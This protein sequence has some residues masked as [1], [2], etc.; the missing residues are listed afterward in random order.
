MDNWF[1]RSRDLIIHYIWIEQMKLKVRIKEDIRSESKQKVY[2]TEVNALNY[3]E[4]ALIFTD[5]KNFGLPIE[6]A[7]KEFNL[8]KSDWNIALGI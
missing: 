3:K 4:L 2:D 7:I 1:S 6:K 8:S 5:L